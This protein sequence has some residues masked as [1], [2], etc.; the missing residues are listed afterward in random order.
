[1]KTSLT[2][3]QWALIAA[4]VLAT[5]PYFLRLGASSLWDSNESFY[6]ETPREMIEARDYVNPTFNYHPRLNKPPLSYWVVASVYNL[7]GV[8]GAAERLPIVLG[9]MAMIAIA[10]GLGRVVF[11]PDAGLLAAIGLAASP[12]FLMFSRRIIIDVYLAMFMALALLM[13]VLAEKQPER[14]RL[15]LVFMYVSI[16]LGVITKGPVAAALPALVLIVYLALHRRLGRLREMMLPL[17]LI[18][19][20]AIVLPWYIAIYAQHGWA[21]IQAFILKD[22]LSRYTQPFWGP[23]RNVFFFLRV[24]M[25]DFFPW[26]LFLIPLLWFGLQHLWFLRRNKPEPISDD[27]VQLKNRLSGLLV[28]WIVVIVVFFSL[29]RSKEDL[30]ILPVYPCAAALVGNFLAGLNG[31]PRS[32]QHSAIRWTVLTLAGII[33]AATVA[34]WYL[35]GHGAL[36]YKLAGASQMACAGIIGGL[37]AGVAAMFNKTRCA[38]LATAFAVIAC[39]WIFVLR[40]LPD[41]ERYRPVRSLCEAIAS[42]AGPDALV[43]YYRAAYPSMVFYLRRPIFEYYLE[44]EIVTAFSSSKEIFCVINARDYEAIRAQLPPQTRV[45]ASHPTFQVKLKSILNKGELP[46]MILISNKGGTTDAQ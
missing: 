4:L 15:Y 10:Y 21:H 3:I 26:S 27:A 38:V 45:L 14:R 39:N 13:F 2:R 8:S 22:N 42:E 44:N 37:A 32:S 43:G 28:I 33:A 36:P 5:A 35:F 17:G 25:G 12:R 41:L 19:I 18:V 23:R 30:Y 31:N 29:S 1:M 9:A 34:T 16:G 11:S 6:A 7:L 24:L 40:V 46:Q 20:A